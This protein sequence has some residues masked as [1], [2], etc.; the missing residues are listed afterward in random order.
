MRCSSDVRGQGG[1]SGSTVD[2]LNLINTS[3]NEKNTILLWQASHFT[4]LIFSAHTWVALI[5]NCYFLNRLDERKR[6]KWRMASGLCGSVFH[7]VLSV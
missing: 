5:T 2:T 3:K 1:A 7:E 4:S 6:K